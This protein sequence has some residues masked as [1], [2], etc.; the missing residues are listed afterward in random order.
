[1]IVISVL[2]SIVVAVIVFG[3]LILIHEFGHFICA[4]LSGVRV[5]EFALGMGP[6][7][8]KH[9]KGETQYSLRLLPIGG[10]VS[11]EGED[12]ESSD[13]HSFNKIAVWKRIII[14]CA[15]AFMN[16]LLGFI[17]VCIIM[18]LSSNLASTTISRFVDNSVSNK[19][20]LQVGDQ[21]LKVNG[22][23]VNI[24]SD[25]IF[26]LITQRSGTADVVIKRANK[27]YSLKSVEFPL[28]DDGNGGKVMNIDFMLKPESKNV[29]SVVN[30]SFYWTIATV[31]LVWVTLIQLFTG[32]YTIKDLS[33]PV[34]VSAAMGSAAKDGVMSLLVLVALITINLGVVNLLPLPALDGGRLVFLIAEA[35]RRKPVKPEVE[36]YIHFAGFVCLMLLVVVVT[37]NDVSRLKIVEFFQGVFK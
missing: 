30:H 13:E 33:G 25:I 10:F 26:D 14:V 4:K 28:V 32:N 11:M 12:K 27:M 7:L 37:F 5:N 2:F 8:L 18:A 6:V 35:I 3:I 19:S 16:I 31:K 9:K 21:I 20:G 36:G 1:V 24:Y 22:Q 34:G 15:G 23:K 17:I 29:I